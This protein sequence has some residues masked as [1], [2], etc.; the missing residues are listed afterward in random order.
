MNRVGWDW[1]RVGDCRSMGLPP[2]R[3]EVLASPKREWPQ[4]ITVPRSPFS[5]GMCEL[6]NAPRRCDTS[7]CPCCC[8]KYTSAQYVS[9]TA[10]RTPSAFPDAD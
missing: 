8:E 9:T 6:F 4:Q 1:T 10:R 3:L 2:R 7:Y 5:A